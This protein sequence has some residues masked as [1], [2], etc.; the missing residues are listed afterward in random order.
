MRINRYL[1]I[2]GLVTRRKA[3]ELIKAGRVLRNGRVAKIGERINEGDTVEIIRDDT[4]KEK[5]FVYI[6]YYK[7]RGIITHSP[8]RGERSLSDIAPFTGVFPVGRLDKES[9][10]LIIL[11]DD[12]RI[13]ERLLHPRFHHEKEYRVRV[14]EKIPR[15]AIK[16]LEAGVP[17]VGEKLS[18][19]RVMLLGPHTLSFILTEGKKHHIRRML[20]V[21]HLT[22]EELVRVRI[23]GISI[24]ALKPNTGRKLTGQARAQFLANLGLC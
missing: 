21:L 10:G 8:Q 11:T 20:S 17:E 23:M 6:A 2:Q 12:G 15:F 24:G 13:T 3:D 5:E 16:I 9:E 7:P 19:K 18:A 4:E 14:R 22:V 1:A